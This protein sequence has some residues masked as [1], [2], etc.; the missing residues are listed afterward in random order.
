MLKNLIYSLIV[1]F[2]FNIEVNAEYLER[3]K[4]VLEYKQMKEVVVNYFNI[5]SNKD[6]NGL[7]EAFSDEV[8]L[9]DWDILAIG[10][11][12]VL[13]ANKNIFDNVQTISVNINEIYI[14]NLTATC[15]I[16]VLINNEEKLSVVDIIKVD[17]EGKI[18]EISAYKQQKC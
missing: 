15:I 14:H 6:L 7:E 12:E 5:F 13:A 10:K 8:I 16:E 11:K 1:I 17:A 9:K 3:G 18:L 2:C 4:G